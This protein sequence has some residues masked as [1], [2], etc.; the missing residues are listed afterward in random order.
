MKNKILVVRILF[1]FCL[2]YFNGHSQQLQHS[3]ALDTAATKVF[4]YDLEFSLKLVG[5][6][7][8][9]IKDV[10]LLRLNS[11]GKV[12][13]DRNTSLGKSGWQPNANKLFKDIYDTIK[14]RESRNKNRIIEYQNHI[15]KIDSVSQKEE[16]L[17]LKIGFD[18][19]VDQFKK[20]SVLIDKYPTVHKFIREK[21]EM[22]RVLPPLEIL[23]RNGDTVIVR[24]PQ[25]KPNKK[26]VI[27][28]TNEVQ[29]VSTL[30]ELA[31]E[32][33]SSNVIDDVE[34]FIIPK[35]Y[36]DSKDSPRFLEPSNRL[37]ESFENNKEELTV[38]F[39]KE[40]TEIE[41]DSI[42]KSIKHPGPFLSKEDLK[43][44][45]VL[46]TP[47]LEGYFKLNG[48]LTAIKSNGDGIVQG[49]E[50]I[51]F[52]SIG[53]LN[54]KLIEKLDN[55]IRLSNLKLYQQHVK[56]AQQFLY[57][58]TE[59]ADIGFKKYDDFFDEISRVAASNSSKIEERIKVKDD[60][61]KILDGVDSPVG[62]R[63]NTANNSTF[64]Y[65]FLARNSRLIKPDFGILYYYS[66]GFSGFAPYTGVHFDIRPTNENVPFWQIKGWEKFLTFQMGVPIFAGNLVE[67]NRR[68]HLVADA[69]SLYGGVGINISHTIRVNYGAILFRS[70]DGTLNG[71]RTF[72]T[73]AANAISLGINLKLK[74]LFEGIYGSVKSITG[75]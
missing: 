75:N 22:P 58:L 28:A 44:S 50:K 30:K 42:P 66:N 73:R 34:F 63:S 7:N 21:S 48:L 46:L 31:K 20:D 12:V 29:K 74:S 72:K 62:L 3:F 8:K 23:N 2:G 71:E 53:R 41:F 68:E 54:I 4:P 55:D 67:G 64:N 15:K 45:I 37:K 27:V 39:D 19:I 70:V 5:I 59:N 38:L 26:Y 14:S 32:Y 56:S 60:I 11:N 51:D 25:L 10:Y 35:K 17:K 65:Q 36:L 69:F 33:Y 52:D 16:W 40:K 61:N 18:S 24:V 47:I 9:P 13:F 43:D 57:L 1:F 6:K 49:S